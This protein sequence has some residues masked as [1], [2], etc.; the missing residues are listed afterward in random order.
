[1][2]IKTSINFYGRMCNYVCALIVQFYI[3]FNWSQWIFF[4]FGLFYPLLWSYKPVINIRGVWELRGY[5]LRPPWS[6]LPCPLDFQPCALIKLI[7]LKIRPPRPSHIVIILPLMVCS[8]LGL[9]QGR[10]PTFDCQTSLEGLE[11]PRASITR[12]TVA[13]TSEG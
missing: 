8:V 1:M 9:S 2:F 3:S 12:W 5:D 7:I 4:V 10:G 13:P 6:E 11:W